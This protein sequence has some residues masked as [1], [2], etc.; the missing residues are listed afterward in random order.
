MGIS[1]ALLEF[2]KS[3]LTNRF[4]RVVMNGQKSECL[5]VITGVPQGSILGPLF[6]LI[7]INDLLV[8]ITSTVKLFADDTSLFSIVHDPNTS[9]NELKKDLQKI[10]ECAYQWKMSFNPDKD[11]KTQEVIFSRKIKKSF[12]LQ[13]SF[14]NMPVFCVNFRKHLG[15]YLDEKLNFNYRIK[16]KYIKKCRELVLLEN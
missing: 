2:I 4:H 10:S 14:N 7:Y 1:D 6:F 15:I 8:G 16:K 3:F 12:H 5:L 11:K 9:A 13:I